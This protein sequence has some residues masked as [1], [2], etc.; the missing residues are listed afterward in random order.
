MQLSL[1]REAGTPI[2][3]ERRRT[4]S[5]AVVLMG[6]KSMFTFEEEEAFFRAFVTQCSIT[7]S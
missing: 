1:I 6:S 7:V 5:P 4:S 2:L 3:G